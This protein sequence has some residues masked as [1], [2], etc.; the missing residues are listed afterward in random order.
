MELLRL[1]WLFVISHLLLGDIAYAKSDS[2]PAVT[3][4]VVF[5]QTI[6]VQIEILNYIKK[7]ETNL[8]WHDV[9][10]ILIAMSKLN[11][12]QMLQQK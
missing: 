4:K 7:E 1:I 6:Q 11:H 3:S 9:Y 2:A 5:D 12:F 10:N 8:K